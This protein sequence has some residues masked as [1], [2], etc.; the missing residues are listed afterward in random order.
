MPTHPDE[1]LLGAN[2]NGLAKWAQPALSNLGWQ[3]TTSLWVES[4]LGHNFKS[5]HFNWSIEENPKSS[6]LE[7]GQKQFNF[8][9]KKT[10]AWK[11]EQA[12]TKQEPDYGTTPVELND[13]PGSLSWLSQE[14]YEYSD[15]KEYQV[16]AIGLFT[17]SYI[18]PSPVDSINYLKNYAPSD[19]LFA[20]SFQQSNNEAPFLGSQVSLEDVF[21]DSVVKLKDLEV[22][23]IFNNQKSSKGDLIPYGVK[24]VW[25]GKNVSKLGN[26][27]KGSY[28][29]IIDSGVS[30]KTGDLLLQKSWSKSWIKGK[31]AF[32]DGNG[33][34][35]HVAGTIGA[36]ANGKGVVGVAPGAK[37]V[38]LKVFNQSGGGATYNSI[39]NAV[40]YAVKVINSNKLDKSKVV[41]NMSLGGIHSSAL[42]S[43]IKKAADQ[44]IK[45]AIA[46]G[47]SGMD[48]DYFS[49][50]SAG[51]HPNV[52]TISAVNNKY[53][54]ASWSNWDNPNGGDDVDYAAP[55]V[56]V[57]S[58][59]KGKKLALMSGTSMAAPH[60]AGLLLTGGVQKGKNVTSNAAG[61]TDPFALSQTLKSNK[62]SSSDSGQATKVPLFDYSL[63]GSSAFSKKLKLFKIQTS[64]GS[65]KQSNLESKLGFKKGILDSSL[66]NTQKSTNAF[67]GSAALLNINISQGDKIAFSYKFKSK[68]YLPYADFAFFGVNGN[69][70][71]LASLA[72]PAVSKKG[73]TGKFVYTFTQK[74]KIK[75]GSKGAEVSFGVVDAIDGAYDSSL[76]IKGLKLI[77]SSAAK[78]QSKQS[79]K[80]SS[81]ADL[82][83]GGGGSEKFIGLSGND[84]IKG[85]DGHDWIN[86]GTGTDQIYGG[87]GNDVL[88]GGKGFDQ[89]SG[90][91]G[92]DT[93][94]L[95]KGSGFDQILDFEY[96]QD[97]I[98]YVGKSSALK[99]VDKG[100]NL[101]I[102]SGQ[103]KLAVV[104]NFDGSLDIQ[105]KFLV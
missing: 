81:K 40:N 85:M 60:V 54:M 100:S 76:S 51:D 4:P 90:G 30:N 39:I 3:G 46:A 78:L 57:L 93:F 68:D 42:D 37:I 19:K 70:T 84:V 44:G 63:I 89:I 11:S 99:I 103:D 28:A 41:V 67:E 91:S 92:S 31:S 64:A 20:T 14:A 22:K 58:Y 50:A 53:K 6:W 104:E 43:T 13:Y 86:G 17:N 48:A 5:K 56:N 1:L 59:Y 35:T 88:I 24:A 21:L 74:D 23:K 26:I 79:L 66:A 10:F 98:K 61:Y 69:V 36:L 55:G 25:G 102:F 62:N 75:F 96:G 47:N 65:L 9:I 12:T 38:S 18:Y 83:T 87:F 73:K 2:V 95:S 33:H 94:V 16:D 71:S 52:Y 82:L 105:N 15:Q 80:G 101:F 45:F 7:D 77:K 97:K 72:D 49:P 8:S 29:F 32:S 27:G 34:G